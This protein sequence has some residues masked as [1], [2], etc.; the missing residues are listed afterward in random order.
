VRLVHRDEDDV[1]AEVVA[2]PR[3]R[4]GRGIA[5][6]LEIRE[7][8]ARQRARHQVH[9]VVRCRD[10]LAIEVQRL[11]ADAVDHARA[12]PRP[13]RHHAVGDL[14]QVF[15]PPPLARPRLD[16]PVQQQLDHLDGTLEP[17]ADVEEGPAER[18]SHTFHH[19]AGER[20]EQQQRAVEPSSR[21]E[22]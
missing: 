21:R 3:D 18:A 11:V 2:V 17:A 8:L 7:R 6:Q 5:A 22:S 10:G 12:L 13:V 9:F 20:R 15:E 1:V 19:E 16:Q 14:E 4:L